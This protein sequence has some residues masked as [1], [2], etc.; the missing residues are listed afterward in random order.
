MV[1]LNYTMSFGELYNFVKT[2]R[3]ILAINTNDVYVI[4][5]ASF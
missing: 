4:T 5:T 1:N 3:L 2:K